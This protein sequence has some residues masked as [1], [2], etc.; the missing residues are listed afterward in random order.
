VDQSPVATKLT[1]KLKSQQMKEDAYITWSPFEEKRL[2]FF[3]AHGAAILAT[4]ITVI[5]FVVALLVGFWTGG[6]KRMRPQRV[7]TASVAIALGAVLLWPAVFLSLPKIPVVVQTWPESQNAYVQGMEIPAS[8]ESKIDQHSL[9]PAANFTPDIAWVRQQLVETSDLRRE[10]GS[11]FQTNFFSGQPWHEE[12]SP[13]NYTIRQ[14]AQGI[15]YLW[16]D[17]E[18]GEH[19]V[20]LFLNNK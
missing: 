13:G 10:I 17:I 15:E 18:G 2:K 19:V 11:N 4:N 3:S 20:P 6:R 5:L 14:T 9:K 12:D 8:L 16:Y 7:L 1:A